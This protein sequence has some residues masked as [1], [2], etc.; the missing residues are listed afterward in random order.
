MEYT[1]EDWVF[2]YPVDDTTYL[3]SDEP[4]FVWESCASTYSFGFLGTSSCA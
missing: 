4:K 3:A 2:K 1:G